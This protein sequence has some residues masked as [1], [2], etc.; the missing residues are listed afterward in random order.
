MKTTVTFPE[1][2]KISRKALILRLGEV[3]LSGAALLIFVVSALAAR[4]TRADAA[5]P[6]AGGG[7]DEAATPVDPPCG[8]P[9]GISV[10]HMETIGDWH[11]SKS[12]DAISATLTVVPGLN[13]HAL[14]LN[15]NLGT[16]KGAWVQIRRDYSPGL[17]ISG[18]DLLR[19]YYRGTITNTLEVGLTSHNGGNYLASS[20]NSG[21]LV[22]LYHVGLSRL[23][24]GRPTAVS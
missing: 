7:R 19:F 10:E 18:G 4:E 2:A 23:A 13:G 1:T 16:T 12:Y 14:Q 6:G 11:A 15:Y 5:N 22:D 17:G 21:S 9:G 24:E 8:M 3:V 20:W